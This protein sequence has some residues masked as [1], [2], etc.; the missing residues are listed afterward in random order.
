[1][2]ER[3]SSNQD[4]ES[5]NRNTLHLCSAVIHGSPHLYQSK[6]DPQVFPVSTH[7]N[8]TL[9]GLL[10]CNNSTIALS[11]T[12]ASARSRAACELSPL[13]GTTSSRCRRNRVAI[14]ATNSTCPNF[15]PGHT[16]APSDH[17]TYVPLGGVCRN[18]RGNPLF[19]SILGETAISVG[20]GETG[21]EA[22]TQRL[23]RQMRESGPQYRG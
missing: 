16:R 18:S 14:D 12:A 21:G 20:L 8:P 1:M 3:E 6:T 9:S 10:I 15:L 13:S 7:L 17:G 23:G 11:H 4:Q 2:K 22:R 5:F 19:G